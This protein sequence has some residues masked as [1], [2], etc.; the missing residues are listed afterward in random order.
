VLGSVRVR[1]TWLK[2][3]LQIQGAAVTSLRHYTV[4]C[5][6]KSAKQ[7]IA[8][9]ILGSRMDRL[10]VSLKTCVG[11]LMASNVRGNRLDLQR[12]CKQ[13][14]ALPVSAWLQ[15]LGALFQDTMLYCP[16]TGIVDTSGD[17]HGLSCSACACCTK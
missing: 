12:A 11:E 13:S 4:E 15:L 7:R 6:N 1:L 3:A 5:R 8:L 17:E 10:S 9:P 14:R 16:G 2:F